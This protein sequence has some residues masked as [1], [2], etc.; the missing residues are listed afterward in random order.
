[1]FRIIRKSI[2][3][4]MRRLRGMDRECMMIMI[5]NPKEIG[6]LMAMVRENSMN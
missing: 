5:A 4:R 2:T 6:T 1:M 3:P